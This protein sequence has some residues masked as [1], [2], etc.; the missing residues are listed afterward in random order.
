MCLEGQNWGDWSAICWP[1]PPG[2]DHC[3]DEHYL[4]SPL[5][6][7]S[8]HSNLFQ[9][10]SGHSLSCYREQ[11]APLLLSVP[12][13]LLQPAL[14]RHR[15]SWGGKD[16]PLLHYQTWIE[17]KEGLVKWGLNGSIWEMLHVT[18]AAKL[19]F[20]VRHTIAAWAAVAP[21]QKYPWWKLVALSY[22][23]FFL[24]Y[25]WGIPPFFFF[26]GKRQPPLMP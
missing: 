26:E 19:I 14:S 13:A 3:L 20:Q 24:L 6:F 23:N 10:S 2:C 16:P 15:E 4:I 7:H 17:G 9:T 11:T 21:V 5:L 1:L 22:W 18:A 25:V 12:A 8:H